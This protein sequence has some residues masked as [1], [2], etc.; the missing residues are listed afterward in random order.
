M[1]SELPRLL[2]TVSK[3]A[4]FSVSSLKEEKLIKNGT[5]MKTESCKLYAGEFLIF[6]PNVINVDPFNF[7]LYSFKVGAFLRHIVHK[8][9]LVFEHK[10]GNKSLCTGDTAM[11]CALCTY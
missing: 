6:L 1:A 4:L 11:I 3:F 5:Y 2:D 8:Y 7:E 9:C 10:I